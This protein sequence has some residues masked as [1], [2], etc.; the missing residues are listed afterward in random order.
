[1]TASEGVDV[2]WAVAGYDAADLRGGTEVCSV[3]V[4]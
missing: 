2:R 4:V 3:F 1:M